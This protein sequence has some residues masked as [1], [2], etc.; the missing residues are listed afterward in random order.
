MYVAPI[1]ALFLSDTLRRYCGVSDGCGYVIAQQ[2]VGCIVCIAWAVV[3]SGALIVILGR[4]QLMRVDLADEMAGLDSVNHGGAVNMSPAPVAD[5]SSMPVFSFASL[6]PSEQLQPQQQT[7]AAADSVLAQLELLQLQFQRESAP[8]PAP[9]P[10]PLPAPQQQ[11]HPAPAPSG[12]NG[13]V[14]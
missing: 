4:M 12:N 3:N 14:V 7:A 13:N 1:R 9:P 11:Q 2:I 6:K 10:A 5:T 8:P